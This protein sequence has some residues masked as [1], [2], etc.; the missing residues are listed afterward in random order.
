MARYVDD[1]TAAVLKIYLAL[2]EITLP[3]DQLTALSLLPEEDIAAYD[4]PLGD[5]D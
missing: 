1:S 2:Q 4:P 3:A 5:V